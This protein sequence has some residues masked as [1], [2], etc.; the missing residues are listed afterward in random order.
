MSRPVFIAST[1][2][3]LRF[4]QFLGQNFSLDAPRRILAAV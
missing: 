2:I 3:F 1:Y 4:S